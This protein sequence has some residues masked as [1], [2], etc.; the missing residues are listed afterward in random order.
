MQHPA[1]GLSV[2]VPVFNEEDNLDPLQTRLKTVLKTLPMPSEIIYVDD[3]STDGSWK[4]LRRLAATDATT[5]V[6]Q[7]RRNFGQASAMAA[8]FA[9]ARYPIV[10]TLDADLQN[11]PADIPR[12]LAALDDEHDVVAGWRRLRQDAWLTRLLP[13]RVANW[14][15]R[16]VTGVRLHDFGCTLR[17]YRR[18]ILSDLPLFGELHRFLPVL[19][20]W[21]GGR[22]K[23]I[24]VTHHPRAHGVSKYG[25]LRTFKVIVDL[26]T[27]K[28]LRDFSGRPNYVF[29]GFGLASLLL[30]IAAFAVVAY[31]VLVLQRLEATPMV[32]LMVIFVLVGVLSIFMGFL[33]EIVIRGFHDTTL[34][35]AYYV[36]QTIGFDGRDGA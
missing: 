7:L 36:R 35:P 25:P 28:F 22:I 6:V 20:A 24:D 23:E 33:A 30:G 31:R 9:H 32:F 26:I 5:A 17:A 14:L 15:I 1:E 4:V 13:S 27:L 18:E 29:G 21:V 11:D 16:A 3:G 2:V 8:G 34:K 19:A 12:L 10:V